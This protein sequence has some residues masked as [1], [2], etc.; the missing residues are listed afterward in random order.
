MK[1]RR[2]VAFVED[3]VGLMQTRLG[4]T[5]NVSLTV[6]IDPVMDEAEIAPMMFLTLVENAFKH[7]GQGE[8]GSYVAIR[9]T[10]SASGDVECDV[11]NSIAVDDRK[12]SGG[13]GLENL[14]R[15]LSLIYGK[16]GRLEISHE[17]SIFVAQLRIKV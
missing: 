9:I 2:E 14:R 6:E 10:T 1:L 15:R 4:S 13:V 3:Y 16:M 5:V 11:A 8:A 17:N 7:G 12:N